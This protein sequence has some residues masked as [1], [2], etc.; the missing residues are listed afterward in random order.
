MFTLMAVQEQLV[1]L[2]E[3]RLRR[4][5]HRMTA[6]HQRFCRRRRCI[7]RLMAIEALETRA[8]LSANPLGP[9][10]FVHEITALEESAPTAA[11]A[12]NGDFWASWTSFEQAGEDESG[13]GV[14]ARRFLADG[15][16]QGPAFLVNEE[17][18]AGDQRASAVAVD[19]RG[20]AVVVWQSQEQDGDGAGIYGQR[21]S[22][23]GAAAGLPFQVNTWW[24]GDQSQPAVAMSRGGDF[25][26]A[27]QSDGQDSDGYGIY[28]RRFAADGQPL[29]LNERLVNATTEGHQ[30]A[31]VIAVDGETD[32]VA[33]VWE[34]EWT[35]GEASVEIFASL[36]GADGTAIRDEFRVNTTTSRDQV[37]P[38]VAIGAS[39][40]FVVAWT[41]EGQPGSG[42][43]VYAQRIDTA[44]LFAGGEF[45][46][47]ETKLQ[48]QQNAA[49]GMD[50]EGSF[51]VTW[52]S[53]HQDAFSWGIFGRA[54]DAAG[55]PL[56]T[57][58]QV[59][60]FAEQPQ[61]NPV[62]G[63]NSDGAT[64]TLWL[65]LD[66]SHVPAVHAQRH[67][68]PRGGGNFHPVGSEIVV[69]HRNEL[70]EA[71][72]AVAVDANRNFVAVWQ[73][74]GDDGNG[75][76]IVGRRFDVH[77]APLGDAFIINTTVAGNQ[78]RPDVAMD[79]E[80][81]FV[82]VWQSDDQDG[83]GQ[84]IFGQR[85]D[86]AGQRLETEFRVST[87]ADGSQIQP[88]IAMETDGGSFVVAWQ[89]PDADGA[90]IYAQRFDATGVRLGSQFLVNAF[91]ELDQASPRISMNAS[92]QF[93][94]AWVSDHRA[95]FDQD[96]SEKSIFVQW[97]D[98]NGANVCAE[99]LAHLIDPAAEA[100]EYPDI[101][102][103]ADGS[104]VVVWQSI[105]QDGSAWGVYGRQFLADKTAREAAEFQINQHTEENQRRASVVVD[106]LGNFTVSWQS[107][108]QDQSAT[109]IMN[110]QYLA[111]GTPAT[112]EQLV[113]QWE[114][115]PQI[116]PVMAMDA[117]GDYGIFWIGQGTAS[118][119]GLHGRFYEEGY[120]PPRPHLLVT[121]NDDQFLVNETTGMS[122]SAPAIAVIESTGNYVAAWTS[123]EQ[124]GGDPQGLGVYGQ[125]FLADGAPQ[126][127]AFLVS[128]VAVDDQDSASVAADAAGNFVVVWESLLQDG[129]GR[130][131]FAQ[132]YLPDGTPYGD[133][134]QVNTWIA[135]D[136]EAPVVAMNENGNFVVAW[137]GFDEDGS[138][139]D[140]H[141]RR[142]SWG[143]GPLDAHE[144]L[145]NTTT[146]GDQ[147]EPTIAIAQGTGQ[148]VIAWQTE[149]HTEDPSDEPDV[150]IYAQLYN[151]EGEPSRD[152]FQVNSIRTKDQVGPQAAMAATGDFVI[153]W[154]SEGQTSSGAD[155]FAR[156]FDANGTERGDDFRVNETTAQGQQ[157]PAV[158]MDAVGDFVISWQSSHQDGFSWG[159]FAQAYDAAGDVLADE[160]QVNTNTQGPQVNPSM[161]VN[162]SGTLVVSWL[163]L[164]A[165]HQPAIHAQRYLLQPDDLTVA[166]EGEVVLNNYVTLEEAPTSAA[167]DANGNF[168]A[169]WQSYGDDGSGLGVF[170][171]RFNQQGQP[172]GDA[173]GVTT[174]T[175]GNQ[176]HP[177]VA[178][179]GTG[180][181]VATWQAA[182]QDG[183]G[184]GIFAQ[185]FDASGQ[186]LSGPF[187]VNSL[188]SGNQSMPSIA[189]NP[190]NGCFVIV[191]QGPDQD[192]FGIFGQRYDAAGDKVG[193]EFLLNTHAA[194]DQV[195]PTA[196]MNAAGQFVVG[197]VSDHRAVFDPTDSE[198]S[199]FVQWFD[200]DGLAT[201]EEVLVHSIQAEFEAQEHPGVAINEQ[202][203]FVVVWQ[204]VN[205]DGN[206]WG[207]FGRQFASDK[208]PIQPVEFQ[209][210][211]TTLAPQRHPSVAV[212]PHGN[213]VVGWQSHKQ[214]SSGAGVFARLYD[215]VAIAQTDEFLVPS[216]DQGPQTSPVLAMTADGQVGMFWTGHGTGRAEGVH[217][218]MY[219]MTPECDFDG[220]GV[221]DGADIDQL[222]ANI[223][224]G[225]YE[226]AFDLTGEGLVDLADRDRWLAVAGARQL[227]S[228]LPYLI[229]DANL[230]GRV[231]ESDYLAWNEHK[232]TYA[233][234]W[235]AGDFNADGGVDVQDFNLWN[236][237]RYENS[238]RR[239]DSIFAVWGRRGEEGN[240][241]DRKI[242][243]D[244]LQIKLANV[245]VFTSRRFR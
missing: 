163:G 134:F 77:G 115:G 200:E 43:D 233:A 48:G 114:L 51:L 181:F 229:G 124:P 209:V 69:G 21:Y 171:R 144:F 47:N 15:A 245:P 94:I 228:G 135:G 224:A 2:W 95:I 17:F 211:Q 49:V 28:A 18:T 50:Q 244:K 86:A 36:Y 195:R 170:G 97:F 165:T 123:F 90:G 40:E 72:A 101:A 31:P 74:Y 235:T 54:Y 16:P 13:T 143:Q 104:F 58:F 42:S 197:W 45:R 238:L 68:L 127:D 110:R 164:D 80:G 139:T 37:A 66:E 142:F 22:A 91:T 112:D 98:A 243:G 8:L 70:E 203:D 136:Q 34:S 234:A 14:Y 60:S 3:S 145:V 138:G 105:N 129:D 156:R 198:K 25:V 125:R 226:I 73:S 178:M 219:Q 118:T 196:A 41:S 117:A 23:D 207:V 230:D 182:N 64:V 183:D 141:G 85:F 83:A 20:N 96:D 131:I 120:V 220:S 179:D 237:H 4:P 27:W 150:E 71:A 56:T 191:W 208:T 26:V 151:A 180:N 192:G 204:S 1:D 52:E 146:I 148:F 133:V 44:G 121:P 57:E 33:I 232:F 158:A 39:G 24:M 119:E 128:G 213:F 217:G 106:P 132:Q 153:T 59:N 231:N 159:I 19:A 174:M 227:P 35:D 212:D 99:Q 122:Q 137:E 216:A 177:D 155:V 6:H 157:Y 185:R 12:A 215:A 172:L 199:I 160:F 126:G 205:Q 169:V 161:S 46:V 214:D 241:R 188:V 5:L 81:N 176:S 29:D 184:Y 206:T 108:L 210:N 63:V 218:R 102:I 93:A 149:L 9:Q 107:D 67:Q 193:G 111:D 116:L 32:H 201:G 140:I 82:V 202:G 236:S 194:L 62:I 103:A 65:G 147:S 76:G 187:Q 221:C 239:S 189:M 38:A 242:T 166:G 7:D 11:V 84:G 113:N 173:F 78:S 186:R 240:E 88:T 92:G 75:T 152:E 167:V 53:S 61:T 223:A 222:I 130:G 89:G 154:T 55:N 79:E 30:T 10:F 225:N 175:I 162:S 100:Q 190:S 109:A 168:V 87:D